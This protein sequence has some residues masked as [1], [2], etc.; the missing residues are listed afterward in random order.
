M[1]NSVWTDPEVLRM[2]SQDYV[3]IA[4]YT[5]DRTTLPESEWVTS[6]LDGK[7]LKTMGKANLDFQIANYNTNTIP[8]HVI[9][10]QDGTQHELAVTFDNNEFREFVSKGI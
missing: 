2:L 5:D 7:V 1:E 9:I 10:D 6:K 4:L 3:V 8:Y